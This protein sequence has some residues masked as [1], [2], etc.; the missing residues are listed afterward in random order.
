MKLLAIDTS[1]G[2]SVA[3]LDDT[4][5]LAQFTDTEHG[6]QGEL[7]AAKISQLLIQAKLK[8][9]DI[10]H[11]VVGVGPG[12]FTGLRVGIATA[13]A[14]ALARN[15]SV[16]GIC[17][18]DAVAFEFG[19]P[20]VVL[21]DARRKELYWASYQDSRVSGPNVDTPAQIAKFHHGKTF[22][23]PAA[24]H[25]PDLIDGI[26]YPLNASALGLLFASGKA[27]LLP[28]IP[29]YLRKPDAKES[30][31]RKSVL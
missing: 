18:L 1:V 28:I 22:V 31:S 20:C 2:V 13:Q 3:V 10:E 14:F 19:A 21:T 27:E 25:Y 9:T 30:T 29:L 24:Q 26:S 23:G 7:T 4:E 6:I 12:P 17:S 8:V 5:V 15:I 11:V 16:S